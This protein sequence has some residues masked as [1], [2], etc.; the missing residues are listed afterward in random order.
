[1][2]ETEVENIIGRKLISYKHLHRGC[3]NTH[4]LLFDTGSEIIFKHEDAE[5][6]VKFII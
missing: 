6:D 5:G 1:M 4:I 2:T 3:M